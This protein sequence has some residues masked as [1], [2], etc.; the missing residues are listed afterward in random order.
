MTIYS[1]TNHPSGFYIYAYLRS[2]DSD[3][4]KAGT[5]YY[6]GKGCA[7]RAWHPHKG[8]SLPS[9]RGLIVIMEAGLTNIGSL[10]LERFYIKWYG[11]KDIGTGILLNRTDGGEGVTNPSE[12]TRQKRS[13]ALKGRSFP[14]LKSPKSAAWKLKLSQ[15]QT[16]VPRGPMSEEQKQR[17]STKMK[18]ILRGKQDVIRCPHC[19]KE[20]GMSN[21]RRYHFDNC[22]IN[23]PTNTQA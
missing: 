21:M 8:I 3:I 10:A 12:I 9:D 7:G 6:I 18:G 23:N 16:G 19:N 11:R 20:G 14:H 22:K 2:K 5:P 4:A 1:I 13:E 15:R 17:R